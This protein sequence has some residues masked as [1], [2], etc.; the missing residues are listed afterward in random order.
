MKK[1]ISVNR[2]SRGR[3][4]KDGGVHPVSAGR[5][6]P[7]ILAAVDRWVTMQDDQPIRSEAIRRLV[8]IGLSL[9]PSVR[10]AA[11]AAELAAKVIEQ[12]TD[13]AVSEEEKANRKRRLIKGPEALREVRVDRPKVK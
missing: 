10:I 11:R 5:I 7:D 9:E 1:V 2:N 13:G 3:P 6:P 12:K 8:E 4:K